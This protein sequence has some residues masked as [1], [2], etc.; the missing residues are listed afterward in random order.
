M[1]NVELK[2][3]ACSAPIAAE[4]TFCE[5]CGAQLQGSPAA[6][7]PSGLTSSPAVIPPA[8]A[9]PPAVSEDDTAPIPEPS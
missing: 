9:Q 2:C 1:T 7:E 4:D 6:L 5:A 8:G 3:P